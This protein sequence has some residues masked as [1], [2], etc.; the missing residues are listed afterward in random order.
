[1][2]N[3]NKFNNL[4]CDKYK[5]KCLQDIYGNKENISKIKSWIN[6]FREKKEGTK[7]GL[8]ISGPPGIG[9]T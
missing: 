1:M 9:K 4:W 2:D 3:K 6:D 8:F 7:M 5:P